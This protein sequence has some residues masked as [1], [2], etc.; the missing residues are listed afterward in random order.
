MNHIDAL[1]K[2]VT[3]AKP[4]K[5]L[6]GD[7]V[8]DLKPGWILPMLIEIDAH[9]WGRWAHWCDINE[10]GSI[11]DKPIPKIKFEPHQQHGKKMIER[12][13]NSITRYGSWQGWS[14]F[15]YFNYFL[16]W[17][18][19][20]FGH[21]RQLP[22]EPSGC[23]GASMR[24]YQ[25]FNLETLVAF[26][27]DDLGDMLAENAHGKHN[28]FFPTPLDICELMVSMQMTDED[29]RTKTVNDP[30]LGTGRM[31]L[32]A[33]NHSYR[34]Y[35]MDI[36]QTVIK[37][38]LV[39]GYLY[40]PWLVKSFSFLDTYQSAEPDAAIIPHITIATKHEQLQLV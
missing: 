10:A 24:L 21:A 36:D 20:A 16:D 27:N 28:G 31:L 37:A 32:C 9:T 5:E 33:S 8:R 23:E 13:L 18:L 29:M 22:K 30:C 11:G 38:A 15:E 34:L 7:L 1:R 35:G 39:N 40:A 2:A 4:K 14:S 12:C 19:Y 6:I 3:E 17:L 25:L 26:P